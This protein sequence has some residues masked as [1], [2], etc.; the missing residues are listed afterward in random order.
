VSDLRKIFSSLPDRGRIGRLIKSSPSPSL[1]RTNLARLIE[2]GGLR[3]FKKLP[4]PRLAAL[5]QLLGGSAYLSDILIREG[6]NWPVLFIRQIKVQQKTTSE[7]L[8]KLSSLLKDGISRDDFARGLRQHKQREFLRIGARDLSSSV[9]VEETVRELAALAEASLE[10]AYRFCRSEVEGDFG[11]LHLPGTERINRFV[12]LGMGKLGGEELNFSSDIDIIFLYEEED[13]ESEGGHKGKITPRGFF[14]NLAERITHAMGEVTEEGFVFRTDLRLRPLG[15]HGPLVQSLGSALLYYESWG[16]CWEQAALIKARP[17]AGD[18]ELGVQ[19]L[20]DIEPFIYRRYLD[21]TTVEELRHMKMRIERE[22]LSPSNRERNL[23]LGRGGI[24]EIEFFTQALQLVNGGFEPRIRDHSTLRALA[25]LARCGLV[26]SRE[27]NKLSHAYRF[28]RDA[29]HKIQMVQEAHSHSIPEGEDAEQALARRL[30]YRR[31]KHGSER[32]LFWRDYRGHTAAVRRAFDRLFYG[33]QKEISSAGASGLAEIWNDLDQERLILEHLERL[34]FS[35]PQRAYH[36]LLAVRDGE[37]YAP[38]SPRRL[39]VMRTLGPALMAEI[40]KSASPDQALFNLAEFS[41]RLGARTGFLSLL[42]ENPKTMRLLINLFSNSQFLTDLFLKRPELLDSLILVDLTQ[43]RKTKAKMADE[44]QTVLS[45]ANDLESQLNALRHYRAEEFI[46]I[47]LH[48]LGEALGL[49]E[50]N[51]QLSDLA[52]ACLE[53]A[54]ALAANEMEKNFGKVQEGRFAAIGMGKLGGREIDYNSD[55]DLIFIYD[56]P[57]EAQGD[58]GTLGC[59]AAHEYYVRLGQKLITFLSAPT[60]EGIVYKI[61]MRL[62][63]SGRA[64]PLVS[65]LEAFRH[66]HQTSSEL[67]ERQALIKARCVA[68]KQGLGNEAQAVAES[69]AYGKGLTQDGIAQIHHLRMRMERELAQEDLSRFNLK[70]GK[71]GMVD[72][73]FLTQMLQLSHGY[74]HPRLRERGTLEALRALRNEKI[75]EEN[76]CRLLSEGYLFLRRL[77]HRLRLERDQSIDLLERE[78]EKLHG[79]AQA[80]G[81]KGQNKKTAGD[82]LLRDYERRRERIRA[83]YERFF[84]IDSRNLSAL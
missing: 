27:A 47:G 70:K 65:S 1:A 72:I 26:P 48:D 64:G 11:L 60:G 67:W 9:S 2:S 68:G 12:I 46:R 25:S 61:D 20:R 15:R 84:K 62:R 58:G 57:E 36:S 43:L 80:L 7:L 78:P 53:G 41:H 22:L 23:K 33:A 29:E 52:E 75:I 76:D 74:R 42:A 39:K 77:D 3:A 54:L 56:A 18:K 71:G 10:A 19:F 59:L 14:T 32:K 50:V 8:T 51:A 4:R 31:N 69:F 44:L 30:G 63:P 6:K 35:D 49:E 21:Y 13:G 37:E 40:A 45:E 5:F 55:L 83:C 34:G 81:Y 38:P 17:V 16:Q 66:Y 24:R 82:L 28:L 79:V 73:E